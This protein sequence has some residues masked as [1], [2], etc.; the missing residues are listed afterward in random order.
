[1]DCLFCKIASKEIPA[2]IIYED[3]ATLGILDIHPRSP[4]HTMVIPK[5]HAENIL[6]LPPEAVGPVFTAV[7]KVTSLLQKALQPDGFTI[8]VNHGRV[9]G[10]TVDHLHIHIMPRWNDDG[11]GSVHSVVNNPPREGL[12]EIRMKILTVK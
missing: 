12:E 5:A 8:G 1:M 6:D 2:S 7:K 4:G 9:S 10:Q 3:D 11:G